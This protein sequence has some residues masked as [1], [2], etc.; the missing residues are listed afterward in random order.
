MFRKPVHL[1][2]EHAVSGADRKKLRRALAA[3]FGVAEEA[4]DVLLPPKGDVR[5]AKVASPS[6][7]LVYSADD[8][9]AEGLSA[10]VVVDTSGKGDFV[11]TVF[12]L[13]RCPSLLRP[14]VCKHAGVSAFLVGGADLM[15]PGVQQASVDALAT[16]AGGTLFAVFVPG[17][18]CAVAVGMLT[19]SSERLGA[20]NGKGRL[21]TLV[22][23]YRDSL[24]E[25]AAKEAQLPNE[26]F[27]PDRV[28]SM[29]GCD[30]AGD[31][32]A[33]DSENCDAALT[34]EVAAPAPDESHN[35]AAG[36]VAV[37][38]VAASSVMTAPAPHDDEKPTSSTEEM[39][40]L[41]DACLLQAL[42]TRIKDKDLPLLCGALLTTHLLPCR[43]EGSHV[44]VKK[45][46]H[47]KLGKFLQ[48][49]ATD[50]LLTVR[51]DKRTGGTCAHSPTPSRST[52]SDSP[53]SPEHRPV[54][55]SREPSPLCA[56][57]THSPR[58]HRRR[59]AAVRR[60][61]RGCRGHSAALVRAVADY[62]GR[63]EA[64]VRGGGRAAGCAVHPC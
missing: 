58:D 49:K 25:L 24:W 60:A 59:G 32:D 33:P 40:A 21:L 2:G 37:E 35:A 8:P 11:P 54:D 39:D 36:G 13:W 52:I 5:V 47:K 53:P 31:G 42:R 23:V 30:A 50:G 64:L 20:A 15:V 6:R 46:S 14:V 3:K 45:S 26:G 44:D 4:L 27:L 19:P 7:A 18:P 43:P 55:H 48:A 38:D 57:G 34:D 9:S 28:E 51:E 12:A 10:P 63:G 62:H 61:G 29:M 41:L 22:Q 16:V 1:T 17:N 56:G